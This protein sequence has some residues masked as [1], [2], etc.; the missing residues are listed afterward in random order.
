MVDPCGWLLSTKK[1]TSPAGLPHTMFSAPDHRCPGDVWWNPSWWLGWR[2]R[3]WV[4]KLG[5]MT[6]CGLGTHC[7]NRTRKLGVELVGCLQISGCLQQSYG[8]ELKTRTMLKENVDT[9]CVKYKGWPEKLNPIPP[10]PHPTPL[11]DLTLVSCSVKF[12]KGDACTA[13]TSC[14]SS[15][16]P[17]ASPLGTNPSKEV[18]FPLGKTKNPKLSE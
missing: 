17:K 12:N 4:W 3:V 13:S 8:E 6:S 18:V 14:A 15:V 5:G 16:T 10:S 11:N 1:F 9:T 2:R 7:W